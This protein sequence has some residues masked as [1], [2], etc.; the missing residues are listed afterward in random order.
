MRTI[1]F[2]LLLS[3]SVST[4]LAQD[5]YLNTNGVTCMCPNA[6]VGTTGLVDNVMYTKRTKGEITAENAAFTC[7]SDIEDMSSLFKDKNTFN[8]DI[9]TWDVSTVTNMGSMFFNAFAFNQD[10]SNWDVN[11]V[12]NMRQMFRKAEAFNQPIGD[13]DVSNVTDMYAMFVSTQVFNQPIGNWDVSRVINMKFMFS[14]AGVFNQD[15][16]TKEVTV[17]EVSYTAWDVSKVADMGSMFKG[18]AF[19]QNIGNWDVNKVVNMDQMFRNTTFNQ[20]ISEWRV[21]SVT[22]MSDMFRDSDLSRENYDYLLIGW[23]TLEGKKEDVN[24]GAQGINFCLGAAG[25]ATMIQLLN[26]TFND[27]GLDCN[28]LSTEDYLNS[29]FITIFPNPT[30]D[31]LMINGIEHP[32]NISIYNLLGAKVIAK[33]N[34]DKIDVSEL[35]KG[36]YI[37]NISDGVSQTNKKFVKN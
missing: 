5:F 19:N 27:A 31:F 9:S 18:S 10:I 32:V 24:L 16:N 13:W 4:L 22:D 30:N 14:N 29:E 34:T 23:A 15:I 1:I 26:W 12:T 37:I 11:K 25:H 7:T 35:S 21:V 36:V 8:E 3:F 20:N 2:T 28:G 6:A 33:S 17:N